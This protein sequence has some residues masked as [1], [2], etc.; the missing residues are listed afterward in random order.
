[1]KILIRGANWIGD[2]VMTIPAM[3]ELRRL[4]PDAE[5]TLYTRPW[6]EGV[7]REAGLVDKILTVEP[8]SSRFRE[9]AAEGRLLKRHGFD[10]AILFTNSFQSAAVVRFAGIPKR[11]GYAREGRGI[12]LSDPIRPPAWRDEKHQVYYYLNHCL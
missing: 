10:I 8:K 1:M 2:A 12:L 11:F 3:G 6:A 7:F 9:T 5:M 4:F